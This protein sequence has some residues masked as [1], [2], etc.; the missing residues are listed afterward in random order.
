MKKGARRPDTTSTPPS[1]SPT[2]AVPA[3]LVVA[4]LALAALPLV[5]QQVIAF[6]PTPADETAHLY[7]AE[8]VVEGASLY[9][10]VESA[11]PPL[12]LLPV[13]LLR[14]TGM[15]LLL[16]GRL[17]HTLPFL[18]SAAVLFF[19][20]RRMFSTVAGLGAACLFLL[21][22]DVVS[23]WTFTGMPQVAL[24]SFACLACVAA[25]RFAMAGLLGAC[26]LL[27]GQHALVIVTVAALF[28][29]AQGKR[30]ALRFAIAGIVVGTA[31]AGFFYLSGGTHL[32]E[33]LV[34]RHF[35]HLG[36]EGQFAGLASRYHSWLIEQV[37]LLGPAVLGLALA[38][39]RGLA[40]GFSSAALLRSPVALFAA[41]GAAHLLV[42]LSMKLGNVMYLGPAAP[43]LAALGGYA[44]HEVTRHRKRVLVGAATALWLLT[45]AA[46]WSVA[47]RRAS[48]AEHRDT[49]FLPHARLIDRARLQRWT[50]LDEIAR[51]VA[52]ESPTG[53]TI[54][55]THLVAP[56][57]A[58][59]ARLRV[60]GDMADLAPNWLTLGIITRRELIDRLEANH[61]SYFVIRGGFYA[62]DE[63]FRRY[64]T[65]CYDVPAARQFEPVADRNA[66]GANVGRIVVLRHLA[67]WPCQRAKEIS[68]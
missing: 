11:R 50:N 32:Y 7:V 21:A 60:T 31:V 56:W 68:D 5:W 18:A 30:A 65:L 26:A 22:P 17:A 45:T 44:V 40:R 48:A 34:G 55:G 14:L 25:G 38:A 20:L 13:I 10:Q 29:I 62:Q 33:C 51:T 67:E 42:V 66:P 39:R 57:I 3:Y 2:I 63:S 52:A 1:S 43:M 4:A 64:L 24:L 41:A 61:V 35:F 8:R 46:A 53:A 23:I 19:V 47:E 9:G 12:A 58:L 36:K 37:W 59:R 49:P 27:S 15:P 54:F 16:A 6:A 28:A